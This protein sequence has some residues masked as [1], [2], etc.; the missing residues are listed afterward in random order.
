MVIPWGIQGTNVFIHF[1]KV[2]LL[3]P[4][5]GAGQTSGQ[6]KCLNRGSAAIKVPVAYRGASLLAKRRNRKFT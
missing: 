4:L 1:S 6:L 5:A 2:I 3:L